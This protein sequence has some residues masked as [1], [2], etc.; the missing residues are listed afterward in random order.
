MDRIQS[1]LS[2]SGATSVS[3][4]F[5]TAAQ[6]GEVDHQQNRLPPHGGVPVLRPPSLRRADHTQDVQD[7]ALPGAIM[8]RAIGWWK[9]RFGIE[10]N[11]TLH[12]FTWPS[13]ALIEFGHIQ[14]SQDHLRYQGAELDF[15]GFDEATQI[16]GNQLTYLHSRLRQEPDSDIPIRFRLASNP[17]GI[18]HEFV[19][20][21]YVQGAD[22]KTRVYL[23]ALLSENPGIDQEQYRERLA[24]LDSVTRKQLEEGDWDVE[25]TG[26]FFE[27]E[28]IGTCSTAD[29]PAN[30]RSTGLGT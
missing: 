21:E 1:R 29:V 20:D 26:G 17:G 5:A 4:I 28:K 25:L 2:P 30:I 12:R 15:V 7:L 23:P 11:G 14:S 10:W 22:G 3:P 8:D 9:G 16:P 6:L 24:R 19:R 13:G 18:S 27:A